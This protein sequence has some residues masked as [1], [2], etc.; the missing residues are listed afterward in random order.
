MAIAKK[1]EEKQHPWARRLKKMKQ[2]QDDN[3]KTWDRNLK[4][5]Y[6]GN[7]TNA[8]PG[9]ESSISDPSN[10]IAYGWGLINALKAQVYLQNPDRLS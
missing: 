2:Y 10:E 6:G 5:I 8:L 3:S 4:L 9:L 7:P 1:K